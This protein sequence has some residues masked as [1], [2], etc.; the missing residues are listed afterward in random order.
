[1]F[2]DTIIKQCDPKK[3]RNTF[4]QTGVW[5]V[6]KSVRDQ[7]MPWVERYKEFDCDDGQFLN[8]AVIESKV[9]YQ[10]IE[11]MFNVK[12]NGLK[13]HWNYNKTYFLHSAGGEKHHSTSKIHTFLAETFPEVNLDAL[14]SQ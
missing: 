12:N 11:S 3:V 6:T 1:M 13:R 4:F 2:K 9:K 14:T 5:M 10:D 8:W 7:M